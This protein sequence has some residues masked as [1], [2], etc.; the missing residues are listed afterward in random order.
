M[1]KV[2]L[3]PAIRG[4]R[5]QSPHAAAGEATPCWMLPV[6]GSSRAA[7]SSLSS[8][9]FIAM[10]SFATACMAAAANSSGIRLSVCRDSIPVAGSAIGNSVRIHVHFVCARSARRIFLKLLKS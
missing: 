8:T 9:T 10:R 6:V 5:A 7:S 4:S 3:K 2:S 1:L